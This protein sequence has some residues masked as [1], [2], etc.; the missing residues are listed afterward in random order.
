MSDVH[1][2]EPRTNP[3]DLKLVRDEVDPHSLLARNVIRTLELA[4]DDQVDDVGLVDDR[5]VHEHLAVV[6]R[7]D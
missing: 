2:S 1:P 7:E 3:V 6:D 5:A 4:S